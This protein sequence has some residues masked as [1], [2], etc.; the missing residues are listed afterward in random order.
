MAAGLMY[1]GAPHVFKEWPQGSC[2]EPLEPRSRIHGMARWLMHGATRTPLMY[3][4]NGHRAYE[5]S[6]KD[7]LHVCM[8]WP[9]GL[10]M[11]LGPP[12]C[13]HA[14][15]ARLMY[16]ATMATRLMYGATSTP[17]CIHGMVTKLMYRATRTPLMYT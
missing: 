10:C 13:I 7:T 1:L 2:M 4:W 8:D 11:A 15:A 12:S 3:S 9:R 5:W 16:G 6:H 17:S 14:M